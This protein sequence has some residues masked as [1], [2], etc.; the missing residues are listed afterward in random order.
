MMWQHMLTWMI[1]SRV[2]CGMSGDDS[3]A[4]GTG[5]L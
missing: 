5:T 1:V 3:L 4:L 2:A